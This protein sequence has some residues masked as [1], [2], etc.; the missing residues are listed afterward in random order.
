MY[1]FIYIILIVISVLFLLPT[2]GFIRLISVCVVIVVFM[3]DKKIN[4]NYY[5]V[6][7]TDFFTFIICFL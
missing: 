3:K 7:A 2:F 5:Q 1:F 6:D 4:N